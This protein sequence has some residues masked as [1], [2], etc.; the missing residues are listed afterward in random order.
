MNLPGNDDEVELMLR[1][2]PVVPVTRSRG[3]GRRKG[4]SGRAVEPTISYVYIVALKA[5]RG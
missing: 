4:L 5:P 1:T 3:R 2:N